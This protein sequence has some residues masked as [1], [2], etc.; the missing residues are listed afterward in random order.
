MAAPAATRNAGLIRRA[1]EWHAIVAKQNFSSFAELR[2]QYLD[3]DRVGERLIFNLGSYRLIMGFNFST[4]RL[5]FKE[6]LTL[7][8][9]D[10]GGWKR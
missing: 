3:V 8:E 7:D 5:F 4:N 6:L 9:Y 1:R 10:R 2:M